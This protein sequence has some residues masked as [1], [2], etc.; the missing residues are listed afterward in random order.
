MWNPLWLFGIISVLRSLI[1]VTI[2]EK[3]A[4]CVPLAKSPVLIC[5][6]YQKSSMSLC[7]GLIKSLHL[8]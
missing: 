5:H 6:L 4:V 7:S 2:N 3:K 8:T 1:E